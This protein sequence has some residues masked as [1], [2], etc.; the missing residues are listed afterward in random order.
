MA[1]PM[2]VTMDQ[3][4]EMGL[5][6][7]NQVSFEEKR[8]NTENSKKKFQCKE[9][10]GHN[11]W[12][13]I[14]RKLGGCA[15]YLLQ[16]LLLL[17]LVKHWL[18]A[19]RLWAPSLLIIS[20]HCQNSSIRLVLLTHPYYRWESWGKRMLS[21]LFEA[22]QVV[23]GIAGFGSTWLIPDSVLLTTSQ[24]ISSVWTHSGHF[25]PPHHHWELFYSDL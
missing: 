6:G 1:F 14:K 7:W 20:F 8:Y 2:P 18:F 5:L 17:W 25:H 15:G 11:W 4:V 3:C 13:T 19:R 24:Y 22:V 23:G 21:G 12:K 10:F 9:E 16:L